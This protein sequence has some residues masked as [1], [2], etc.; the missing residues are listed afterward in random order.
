MEQSI[1][2][3]PLLAIV[4]ASPHP[5][6]YTAKLL[7]E[8]L[9]CL[10]SSYRFAIV[11]AYQKNAHPCTGCGLCEKVEGCQFHDLDG[12]DTLLREADALVVASPIYYNSFPSPM[13]AILDRMQRYFSARFSLG[14]KPPISKHKKAVLLLTCGS[15]GE[16]ALPLV[17][18][19]LGM[20]FSTINAELVGEAVWE[21]T[22]TVSIMDT[23]VQQQ[24]RLA[25]Q[26]LDGVD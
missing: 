9:N 15:K 10:P 8:F 5:S 17:R 26:A 22:D 18:S 19:Q 2:E 4:F 6:G 14:L 1:P 24:A 20:V 7:Q 16:Q 11:D 23:G 25:A 13:K 3:Q 12:F 21:N